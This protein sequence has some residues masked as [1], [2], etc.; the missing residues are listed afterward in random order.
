MT[1]NDEL[2]I[3]RGQDYI[4][5]DRI[6]IH[7]PTVDEICEFGEEKY[8]SFVSRL[9]AIP[10][11]YIAQ[12]D[13]IGKK[14][15]D[16][17]DFDFF[18]IFLSR[19]IKKEDSCLLFGD[20][21]FTKLID[22][23]NNANQQ[24]VL[25]NKETDTVIDKYIYEIIVNHVRKMHNFKRHNV[26]CGNLPMRKYL[27]SEARARL[28]KQEEFKSILTPLISA[29]INSAGFK[30]GCNEVWDLKIY[31]FMDSVNRIQLIKNY[32]QTMQGV[33][34]GCIDYNNIKNKSQLNWLGKLE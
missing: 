19:G 20:L 18:R 23:V 5:N 24:L 1:E 11:D 30:Y 32:E 2:Q 10:F 12:L 27:I 25:Y 14:Y 28:N 8:Y 17:S 15:D 33:Y 16:Y 21:D 6:K 34:S 29:M 22:G 4:I 9:V 3:F 26:I 31:A 7:Q 13:D